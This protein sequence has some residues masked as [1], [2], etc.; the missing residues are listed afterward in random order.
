MSLETVRIVRFHRLGGPE[1]LQLDELPLPEPAAGEIRLRVKAIGLNRAEAML[2]MG[3]YLVQPVLPSKLGYEAS[4]TVEAVG[5]GVDRSWLGKTASVVPAFSAAAYGVYGE[6]AVVPAAALAEYP[7]RLSYEEGTSI[8]M[9][10]LT[11]YGALVM[12]GRITRGD[13]V[14]ITAASSSV[15]LAAIEIARAEGAIAIATTRTSRKKA[16][17]QAAGAHHVIATEEEDLAA[18]VKEIGGGRGSRIIFDPIAGKGLEAL[19]AA[20]S[21]GGTIIEYGALGGV[22]TPFPLFAAIHKAWRSAGTLY[23]KWSPAPG[24]S[25]RRRSTSSI[26]WRRATSNRAS[27]GRSRSRR[28]WRPIA[29]W[30]PISRSARS[31]SPS[32]VPSRPRVHSRR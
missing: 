9:Q 1:V 25:P 17:L 16:E 14:V 26:T 18:R 3:Q 13:L 2:R 29:T 4:G 7:D 22:S 15:G 6:V 28:S 8:W 27:T 11:A 23:S 24:R 10:Y 30:N 21:P 12:W 19:A 31:W 20:A 32:S 5:P